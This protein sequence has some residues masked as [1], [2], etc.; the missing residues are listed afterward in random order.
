[1]QDW[2]EVLAL[3]LAGEVFGRFE[4]LFDKSAVD[5]ELGEVSSSFISDLHCRI[6]STFSPQPVP[7]SEEAMAGTNMVTRL[8][9]GPTFL[10]VGENGLDL[11]P[12]GGRLETRGKQRV[13]WSAFADGK[14]NMKLVQRAGAAALKA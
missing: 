14:Q 8:N 5:H 9:A 6:V 10:G 4:F 1:V 2:V 7:A 11:D 12:R 3:D 13:H